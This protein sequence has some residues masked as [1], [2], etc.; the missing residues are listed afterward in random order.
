MYSGYRWIECRA[1]PAWEIYSDTQFLI[2]KCVESSETHQSCTHL[3]YAI[4]QNNS[5]ETTTY[6]QSL[7]ALR[8]KILHNC[9]NGFPQ[10]IKCAISFLSAARGS[11]FGCDALTSSKSFV[12]LH[13]TK[14]SLSA[15]N[16]FQGHM[17]T[18][19]QVGLDIFPLLCKTTFLSSRVGDCVPVLTA[20]T[21]N[22]RM[23][24]SFWNL[25]C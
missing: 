1:V 11:Y 6:H 8:M 4:D 22:G 23:F 13:N 12:P 14:H 15:K 20:C 18:V 19:F 5:P 10:H 21:H 24:R 17:L 2:S 7:P 9:T 3:A 25:S 16:Q